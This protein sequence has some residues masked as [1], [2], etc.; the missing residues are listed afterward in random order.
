[1]D[2]VTVPIVNAWF[3]AYLDIM[4]HFDIKLHNVYNMDETG[5]SIGTMESTRIIVDSSLRTRHQAHPGRQE[6]VSIVECICMDATSIPPLVIF[7]GGPNALQ[8]WIPQ[9]VVNKWYFSSNTN[10]WTSN[11]HGLEWLKRVFEPATRAKA[12]GQRRLL[13]CDGH[14][15][16]I[17]GNF[18]SH[19]IQNNIS[20]LILPPHTSHLLQ[21]LDVAT[22][23]PLKKRLTQ[24]LRHLNEA[25]MSRLQKIEWL[26]AYVQA[27]EQAITADNIES[28]W[29]GAGLQ[30][31]NRQ[32]V[33]RHVRQIEPPRTPPRA[34][35]PTE[36]DILDQVFIHSSPPDSQALRRA[37]ELLKSVVKPSAVLNTPTSRYIEKLADETERLN[38]RN[39]LQQ[40][41]TE[42]LRSIIKTRRARKKGKRAI[43]QGVFHISTAEICG[44]VVAA[45]AETAARSKKGK[46][47]AVIIESESEEEEPEEEPEE[48]DDLMNDFENLAARLHSIVS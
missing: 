3:D 6:W 19:C 25:Q 33:L 4:K 46:A 44:S 1:M 10:G 35:T 29:R 30:P 20:I 37:N 47:K 14:D 24:A 31:L 26:E 15:S 17:S 41:E 27:R 9:S 21:P 12:D 28:S 32:R 39:I 45:E 38:T 2:G 8:S 43:L 40:R 18:I 11:L 23:G 36:F 42:N 16:H 22:F 5:F 13:I 7:K 48:E 34:R